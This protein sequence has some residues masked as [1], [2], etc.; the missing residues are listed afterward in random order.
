MNYPL[1]KSLRTLPASGIPRT[2]I[3]NLPILRALSQ[4]IP[5]RCCGLFSEYERL[6]AQSPQGDSGYSACVVG[7]NR[8][9]TYHIAAVR[10]CQY[11]FLFFSCFSL[12]LRIFIPAAAVQPSFC[13]RLT[14]SSRTRRISPSEISKSAISSSS[15]IWL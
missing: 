9:L 8:I 1:I 15:L 11:L 4:S 7:I 2:E 10:N 14:S 3:A 13:A 5:W 12:R 6:S